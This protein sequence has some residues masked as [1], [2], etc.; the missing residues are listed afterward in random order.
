M[1]NAFKSLLNGFKMMRQTTP[2]TTREEKEKKRQIERII[3]GFSLSLSLCVCCGCGCGRECRWLI[4]PTRGYSVNH[5]ISSSSNKNVPPPLPPPPL[6]LSFLSFRLVAVILP[7]VAPPPRR[8]STSTVTQ[9]KARH[10]SWD[11]VSC[12]VLLLNSGTARLC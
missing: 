5:I 6:P 10:D 4:N 9:G 7:V 2:T 12:R 3:C 11:V 8:A 1:F